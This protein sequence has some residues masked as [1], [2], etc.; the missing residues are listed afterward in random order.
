M[1]RIYER[2]VGKTRYEIRTHGKTVRLY[3]N[4]VMHTQYHPGRRVSGGVW[5]LLVL[6]ALA[7]PKVERVLLLGLGGGAAVHLLREWCPGA[8]I[9]ALELNPV[10]ISLARR[11]FDIKG[12]DLTL[13][14][15]DARAFVESW[16]GA[17]FDL[18]IEDVFQ[19]S[20]GTP[21]R[22]FVA[23]KRW[24]SAL[25]KLVSPRGALVMNT[26]STAALRATAPMAQDAVHRQW[27][28][29][30]SLTMPAYAN[31]VGAFYR[32][33]TSPAD[34]RKI[35]RS[36]ARRLQQERSGQLRYKITSWTRRIP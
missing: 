4:G 7:L 21:D 6:P 14:Q 25:R 10:H 12:R 1:P 27:A 19:D 5:D 20:E 36:D 11:F 3:T 26:L 28:S 34:L 8:H 15:G 16:R 23:D 22:A 17:P 32:Q 29:H 2:R 30:L 24:C 35:I 9:T 13:I 33:A 31:V 18:V